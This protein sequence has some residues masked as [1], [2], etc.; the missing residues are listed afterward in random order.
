MIRRV[1]SNSPLSLVREGSIS[2]KKDLVEAEVW[3][4]IDEGVEARGA[5]SW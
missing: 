1:T 4:Q 2:F 3:L 5:V